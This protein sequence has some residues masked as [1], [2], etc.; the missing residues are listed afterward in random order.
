MSSIVGVVAHPLFGSG[1]GIAGI[2]LAVLFY[3]KGRQKSLLC[4][5]TENISVVGTSD[6]RF[7][8]DLQIN[9][10]GKLVPR[11]TSSKLIVW[12]AGNMVIKRD[13][14]SIQDILRIDLL[15]N[16]E[17]LSIDIKAVSR[18]LVNCVTLNKTKDHVDIS[19]DFLEPQEGFSLEIIH[20]GRPSDIALNGTIVGSPES[21][22][23]VT[24]RIF[25]MM[26]L[27]KRKL[28]VGLHI[29][30]I[31]V[32]ASTS[33][34]ILASQWDL[35][36]ESIFIFRD[37]D[38]KYLMAFCFASIAVIFSVSLWNGRRRYPAA[39]AAHEFRPPKGSH[40][41]VSRLTRR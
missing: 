35:I 27:R 11:V 22:K 8:S 1:L 39:L 6:A 9:Y 18:P 23:V 29:A 3:F 12:N 21:P 13:D 38:F 30:E 5:T 19:F 15:N 16:S 41:R 17:A 37:P 20:S 24:D 40:Q 25:T 4:Y 31:V 14:V 36:P 7:S 33:G 28:A 32:G 2:V 26:G 10:Q 34:L